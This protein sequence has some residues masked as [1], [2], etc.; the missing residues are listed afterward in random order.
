MKTSIKSITMLTI[1]AALII[2]MVSVVTAGDAETIANAQKLFKQ[3]KLAE[4]NALLMELA[5]T[6]PNHPDVYWMLARNFNKMGDLVDIE[7]NKAKKLQMYVECEKWAAKGYKKNPSL[8]DNAFWMA[9]GMSQQTQ[10]KGIAATLLSN[11]TLAKKIEGMFL[12]ATKAK[13]FHYREENTNTISSAH[14]ALGMF[15]R[16]VP[17]STMVKILMGT[18]G[19]ID[20]SIEHLR[21]GVAMF[22]KN[23]E[24]NKEL[25]VSLLC[26]GQK[27]KNPAD[28]KEGEKYLKIVLQLTPTDSVD[29]IDQADAK[30]LLADHSLACGYSRVQQ[31]EVSEESFKK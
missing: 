16:K 13:Q 30:R 15:Y 26:R 2:A 1:A 18:K 23:I 10:V 7:A 9:V 3:E 14:L 27:K 4:S 24:V 19:D 11:R 12:A 6:N 20:K 25:G 31:E 17:D 5:K 21:K 8:A 29:K 28:T 22:P